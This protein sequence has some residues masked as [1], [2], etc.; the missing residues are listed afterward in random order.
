MSNNDGGLDTKFAIIM[1]FVIIVMIIIVTAVLL[2]LYWCGCMK[3]IMV[4]MMVAVTLLLSFYFYLAIG[5]F[6]ELLNIPLD[7]IALA[8]AV[9]NIVGIGDLSIFWR[10]PPIITQFFLIL[11]SVLTS[12]IFLFLPDWT[13]W[14]LLILLVIY[15]LCVVL[16]PGGLLNLLLKKSE[17]RGDSIPALVYS[18]ALFTWH[19]H[20]GES[21]ENASSSSSSSSDHQPE[22]QPET[23]VVHSGEQEMLGLEAA[24]DQSL[25]ETAT[26]KKKRN[27]AEDD[28]GIKL[29]LGDFVFYGI[30]VTRAARLGWDLVILCVFAV[31][32]GLSLTLICLAIWNRPLP[33]LPFSL[34]LGIVFFMIGALTFRNFSLDLR[35]NLAV[36]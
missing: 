1:A 25:S 36:F 4:W 21:N 10:A 12:L 7:Y 31:I 9:I 5:E 27:R 23:A 26:K 22:V 6:P 15:D 32:L 19:D 14:I 17:E 2:G 8:I 33:A 30:L 13:V 20:N 34:V 24:E 18:A 29:G 35:S 3:V 16:C 11:I 28:E